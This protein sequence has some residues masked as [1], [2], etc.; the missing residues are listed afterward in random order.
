MVAG[1]PRAVPGATRRRSASA[2]RGTDGGRSLMRERERDCSSG[3]NPGAFD[4]GSPRFGPGALDRPTDHAV[5]PVLGR[6]HER[7]VE[8]GQ[9]YA[10]P[11]HPQSRGRADPP[12]DHEAML[13]PR[14]E[15]L[16]AEL[17]QRPSP[18]KTVQ[19]IRPPRLEQIL[20]MT[21]D[22][23]AV[24]SSQRGPEEAHYGIPAGASRLIQSCEVRPETVG[25]LEPRSRHL[26]L[27]QRC[28]P[29]P[30]PVVAPQE[31]AEESDH[32]AAHGQ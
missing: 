20:L 15:R 29:D 8:C 2:V 32:D 14:N 1:R 28:W 4:R 27:G 18:A 23:V 13:I 12:R 10:A 22:A 30:R 21:E 7:A 9:G 19:R 17:G 3:P 11:Q 25:A 6:A 31:E 24:R 26:H 5:G 16:P